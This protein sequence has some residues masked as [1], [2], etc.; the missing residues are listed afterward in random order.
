[1]V[2]FL[3]RQPAAGRI[4]RR[5]RFAVVPWV[6]RAAVRAMIMDDAEEA[7]HVGTAAGPFVSSSTV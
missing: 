2:L 5:R 7:K 3:L 6:V 1:L 4:L